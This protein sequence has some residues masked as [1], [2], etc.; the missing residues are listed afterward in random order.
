MNKTLSWL[1]QNSDVK[2]GTVIRQFIWKCSSCDDLLFETKN[3]LLKKSQI[4]ENRR[5]QR[6][7]GYIWKVLIWLIYNLYENGNNKMFLAFFIYLPWYSSETIYFPNHFGWS[8]LWKDQQLRHKE[9][10]TRHFECS[11]NL[12]HYHLFYNRVR[13]NCFIDCN[14]FEKNL[15][16]LRLFKVSTH[17]R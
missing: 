10:G 7:E 1:L 17:N 13:W 8:T 6:S 4:E 9:T 15:H 3:Y 5:T 16:P 2:T 12:L 11:V 14:S